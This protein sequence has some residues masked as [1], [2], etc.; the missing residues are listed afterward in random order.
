MN[1]AVSVE[2]TR[3]GTRLWSPRGELSAINTFLAGV[4]E[5]QIKKLEYRS[6]TGEPLIAWVL[7]PTDYVNGRL[8]PSVV[9]V[10]GGLTYSATPPRFY[11]GLASAG[12]LN[13]QLLAARGYALILPSMPL[14]PE[15]RP[16]DPY[17]AL[18]T[19]FCPL[20]IRRSNSVFLTRSA[21]P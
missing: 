17:R 5:G 9:W 4:S 8:Y 12:P 15:G 10:Y 20:L 18:P 14:E 11:V 2:Q 13:L 16:S 6:L 19:V 21:S 3:D 7:L 1:G